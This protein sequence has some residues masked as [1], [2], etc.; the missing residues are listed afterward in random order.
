M[1]GKARKKNGGEGT[2][3]RVLKTNAAS[4]KKQKTRDTKTTRKSFLNKQKKTKQDKTKRTKTKKTKIKEKKENTGGNGR[5]K[6]VK[7]KTP[8][9]QGHPGRE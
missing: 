2:Q 7:L 3:T 1:R 5:K 8:I 4:K 6:K 9:R